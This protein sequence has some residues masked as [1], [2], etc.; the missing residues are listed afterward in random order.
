MW[1]LDAN[2]QLQLPPKTGLAALAVVCYADLAVRQLQQAQRGLS[3]T[4]VPSPP[5]ADRN[6]TCQQ[7]AQSLQAASL[8]TSGVFSSNSSSGS[9]SGGMSAAGVCSQVHTGNEKCDD[10]EACIHE[11]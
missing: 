4:A 10:Q 2:R 8:R 6:S 3:E 7:A 1:L 5:V 11:S 9:N